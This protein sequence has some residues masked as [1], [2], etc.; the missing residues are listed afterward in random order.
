VPAILPC[1]RLKRLSV[2][3]NA[4][5]R[6][7]SVFRRSA[8]HSVCIDPRE[9]RQAFS[10]KFRRQALIRNVRPHSLRQSLEMGAR[11]DGIQIASIDEIMRTDSSDEQF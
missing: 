6:L 4:S 3:M 10:R 2:Q 11:A 5:G 1:G 8:S 9:M 7:S